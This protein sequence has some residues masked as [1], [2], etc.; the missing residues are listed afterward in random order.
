MVLLTFTPALSARLEV[1]RPVL[2]SELLELVKFHSDSSS[3]PNVA[4]P[5]ID[6]ERHTEETTV[7]HNVLV[8]VSKWVKDHPDEV[9]NELNDSRG[10]FLSLAWPS[11]TIK[12]AK[13]LARWRPDQYR[14]ATLLKLTQV[15]AP[16][17][18]PR[19]KVNTS[20]A[21]AISISLLTDFYLSL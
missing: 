6:K 8:K 10:E 2:P 16:P 7:D 19:E 4:T 1:L 9:K 17:L 21:Q 3:S 14:L 11:S 15:H 12:D 13:I 18:Q 20:R 5:A